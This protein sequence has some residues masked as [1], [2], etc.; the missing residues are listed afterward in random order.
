M[1]TADT[2]P[3]NGD[4]LPAASDASESPFDFGEHRRKAVDRYREVRER[5]D[6][7]AQAVRA[8][9]RSVLDEERIKVQIVEAR[10]KG[11]Q[12]FGE[13]AEK[14]EEADANRPR[15]PEPVR[16][17]TDLA[18]VR[19]IVYLLDQLDQ[20]NALIY[21]EFDVLEKGLPRGVLGGG[22]YQSTHYLVKFKAPRSEL[23]EYERFCNLTVEVQVRTVL[24]H[25]WAEIEHGI[26]YKPEVPV[27]KEIR[28]R[29]LEIAGALRMADREFQRVDSDSKKESS[30]EGPSKPAA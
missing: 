7:C 14:A 30:V 29:L 4:N 2:P 17:I 3:I 23:P 26:V 1:A 13:K 16:D 10:G 22:G 20:V 8:V 15:Y 9:L 18:G 6:E 19:V 11:V 12:S 24:Q 25:G 27:G 5:F 28:T 21:R